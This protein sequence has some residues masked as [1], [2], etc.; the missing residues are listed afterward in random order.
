MREFRWRSLLCAIVCA[1]ATA[2]PRSAETTG[3]PPYK[4][5]RHDE[6]YSYL[7]DASRRSD[8]VDPLKYIPLCETREAMFLTLGGEVRERYEYFRNASWDRA[9]GTDGFLL[10]RYM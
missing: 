1:L 5:L 6:D 8:W 9:N 4:T 7:K 2:E 10:Q 3:P